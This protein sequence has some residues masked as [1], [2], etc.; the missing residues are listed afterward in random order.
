MKLYFRTRKK[1]FHSELTFHDVPI[2]REAN[3]KHLGLILDDRLTFRRHIEE[4]IKSANKGIGLL[5]FLSRYTNRRVLDQ[6][7]KMYVRPHLDYGD[8]IYHDQLLNS[9]DLLESVQYKA[10]IIVSGCWQGTSREKLYLELG[11]ESLKDRRHY[12]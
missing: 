6:M 11:W 2:R 12:R 4:K 8:V 10:A 9:M 5:N 3:T 7:Y 1:P